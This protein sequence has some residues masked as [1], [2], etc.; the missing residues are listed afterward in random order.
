MEKQKLIKV[1][2]K[3]KPIHFSKRKTPH[4][5]IDNKYFISFGR[6][7]AIGCIL[8]EIHTDTPDVRVSV[9][10]VDGMSYLYADEL[11]KTPEEAVINQVTS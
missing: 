5:I 4:L 1:D 3:I 10:T 6:N 2:K 11:G 7:R 8:K 9:E